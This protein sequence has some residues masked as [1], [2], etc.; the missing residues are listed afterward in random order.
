MN[1]IKRQTTKKKIWVIILV[2]FFLII[3]GLGVYYMYGQLE[4]PI[5]KVTG[6]SMLDTS[7]YCCSA[8][9][10]QSFR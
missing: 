6:G 8:Y 10:A 5:T 2:V 4:P 7:V 3:I 9:L 1:V